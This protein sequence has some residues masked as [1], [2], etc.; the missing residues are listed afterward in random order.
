MAAPLSETC[1]DWFATGSCEAATNFGWLIGAL[2]GAGVDAFIICAIALTPPLREHGGT[3][4]PIGFT[5]KWILPL[6]PFLLAILWFYGLYRIGGELLTCYAVATAWAAT[7]VVGL[8]ILLVVMTA[9]RQIARR[10][11]H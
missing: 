7:I 9:A 8:A 2:G 4:E 6:P 10:S 1:M 3:V 5:Q 11:V